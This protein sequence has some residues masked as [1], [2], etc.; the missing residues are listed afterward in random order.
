M[1]LSEKQRCY[2][3]RLKE[4]RHAPPTSVAAVPPNL[5]GLELDRTRAEIERLQTENSQLRGE[6]D[7]VRAEL[8]DIDYPP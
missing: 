7:L 4:Q 5:I 3:E 8:D 1:P 2:R 6:L